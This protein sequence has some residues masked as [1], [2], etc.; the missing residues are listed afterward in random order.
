MINLK[1]GDCL[2]LL[3]EIPNESIDLILT[4]PPYNIS[5]KNSFYNKFMKIYLK[6]EREFQDE[7]KK[8]EEEAKKEINE[9]NSGL[10]S[11]VEENSE[12]SNN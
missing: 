1:C 10:Y 2:D 3:K 8:K 5:K 4:D 9:E 11:D 6:K 12:D 7:V